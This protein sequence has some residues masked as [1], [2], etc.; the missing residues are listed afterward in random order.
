MTRKVLLAIVLVVAVIG[1]L[2]A[3]KV[4]Q[5]RAMITAGESFVVPPEAVSSA[6]ARRVEWETTLS[7][8]GTVSA[9]HGVLLRTEVSGLVM[10]TPFESG[11]VAREGKVLVELDRSEQEAQL[12]SAAARAELARANLARARDLHAKEIL[13]RSELDAAEATFR[14]TTADADALR[15][16]VAKKTVRAPFT[17][18]LG[19][20]QVQA[21]QYLDVGTPLVQLHSLDPVHVEF[22]LPE[23]S[24]GLVRAGMVVRVTSDASADRAFEGLL[25]AVD[26]QV[27]PSSRSLRLQATLSGLDGALLPGMF[28][29]VELVLPGKVTPLVIPV[30]AVLAAPY[31]DSVFVIG[32]VRDEKTGKVS[33]RVRMTTVKL[34]ETR[35]D[36][37]VVEQGLEEGMEIASSGVF[38]LHNDTEVVVNDDLAPQAIAAPKP[39]DS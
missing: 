29:R 3:V 17:G 1:A 22:T 34:G 15:V 9:V 26:P 35:G 21:G 7:A 24:A 30:T 27:D 8:I 36:L 33:R 20:R 11:T 28:A 38:K 18:R 6:T 31:G 13:P 23:R 14:Q 37:V 10:A 19:I 12:R 39:T 2:A 16:A 25:T 5:I 4:M 32:D